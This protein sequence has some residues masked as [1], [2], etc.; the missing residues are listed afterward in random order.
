MYKPNGEKGVQLIQTLSNV[1]KTALDKAPG[2]PTLS[3][4]DF[5]IV[6]LHV[7]EQ[8]ESRSGVQLVAV[9][10]NG[11]RLYFA[12]SS[13]GYGYSYGNAG[14]GARPLQ[15]IHVRLPPANLLHPDELYSQFQ[16]PPTTYGPQS[17]TRSTTSRPFTV[18]NLDRSVYS[19]GLLISAQVGEP[20]GTD[21]IFCLSPDLPPMSSLGHHRYA[22]QQH[23]AYTSYGQQGAQ[24]PPLTENATVLSIPGRTWD[25]AVLPTASIPS[26]GSS[27][28]SPAVTNELARQFSEPSR[29]F[30]I[31]TNIGVT[32]LTKRRALDYLKAVLEEAQAD[33]NVQ[34]IM[35]LRQR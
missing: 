13:I 11:V 8:S 31:L 33:A 22:Q 17:H 16:P 9:T 7:V 1:Q 4:K 14:A 19:E 25:M 26:S 23:P 32:F 18:A 34:P 2:A 29:Q 24:R 10:S 12:A 20:E 3:T 35:E 27:S 21:F 6:A 15:L 5:Q 28:P 30:L